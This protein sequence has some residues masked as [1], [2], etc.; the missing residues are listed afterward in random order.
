MDIDLKTRLGSLELKSP[1]IVGSCP[2]VTDELH[3]ISVVSSG[4]GAIVLP[5]IFAG[6]QA[7][8]F[9]KCEY[10]SV[11]KYLNL[12]ERTSC[13]S[14]PIIASL[15][16]NLSDEWGQLPEKIESAGA[17]AIEL[18]LRTCG[19]TDKNPRDIEDE[20]VALVKSVDDEIEI[21]LFLKLTRNFTNIS[22]FARRLRPHVQ[23][24]VLFGR[25]PVVDIE[26]DSM[27][28]STSWGLTQS[29]SVVQSL[30]PLMR[31]REEFPQMPLAAC[32]GVGNSI[33]LIKALIA[34]ANAAMVTSALYR[35]GPGVIGT[36]KD[37]LAK[38]MSDHGVDTIDQMR[39]L[40]PPLLNVQAEMETTD[41]ESTG[42][43]DAQ[44]NSMSLENAIQC[45]KYGHP[46]SVK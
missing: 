9:S 29:G 36:L 21:P 17:A 16:G 12:V 41:Y 30:E 32:G 23:G 24:L 34:G 4:A 3:R 25:S 45:D 19:S 46:T 20:I 8:P 13:E 1:I 40:C 44:A 10:Q 15:N 33:D 6:G 37:G 7:A 22:H 42:D 27:R 43:H 2:M 31:T 28:L 35:H 5:S 38:F 14:V 11:D 39:S 26:L 18:S